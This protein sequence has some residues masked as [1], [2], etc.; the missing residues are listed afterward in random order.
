MVLH[1]RHLRQKH[2]RKI[3]VT[4]VLAFTCCQY[5]RRGY[6]HSRKQASKVN[7]FFDLFSQLMKTQPSEIIRNHLLKIERLSFGFAYCEW[8]LTDREKLHCNKYRS[9]IESV[10]SVCD[11]DEGMRIGFYQP[12][13]NGC[14]IPHVKPMLSN[15][16]GSH[17]V[18]YPKHWVQGHTHNTGY[19]KTIPKTH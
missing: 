10:A 8:S 5:N 4:F 19:N 3:D 17:S 7:I 18:P 15:H 16:T 6:S 9:V 14:R 11:S 2:Q 12:R 1:I 13:H